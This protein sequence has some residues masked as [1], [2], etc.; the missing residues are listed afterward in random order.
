MDHPSVG[1]RE[2]T[3][4]SDSGKTLDGAGNGG[5]ELGPGIETRSRDRAGA[6]RVEAETDIAG[7]RGE[8]LALDRFGDVNGGHPR[9]RAELKFESYPGV[10]ENAVKNLFDRFRRWFESEAMSAIGAREYQ[11]QPAGAVFE[12]VQRLCVRLRGIRM[13]DP[14]HDLPGQ[15]RG[16]AR[17][18][19][20]A[21]RPRI[22][23]LD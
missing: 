19:C 12:I 17:N 13:I 7:R 6:N 22:D 3:L 10:D 4:E 20:G 23:R 5:H 16:T 8:A 11:R 14:L 15:G 21:A 1:S 9:Q 2:R 18:R